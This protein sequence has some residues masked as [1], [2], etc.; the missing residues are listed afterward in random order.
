MSAAYVTTV[1]RRSRN[2][3][4]VG[5]NRLHDLV[6]AL[7]DEALA[8]AQRYLGFL[9]RGESDLFEWVLNNALVDDEPSTDEEDDAAAEAREQIRRGRHVG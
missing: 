9:L 1:H 6:D 3:N 2:G 5:K 4:A 8:A 7:S